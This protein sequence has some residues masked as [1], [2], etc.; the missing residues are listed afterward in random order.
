[1]TASV[2]T[3]FKMACRKEGSGSHVESVKGR[4]IYYI[5]RQ[6]NFLLCIRPHIHHNEATYI[7]SVC[8]V[9]YYKRYKGKAIPVKGRGG[10]WDRVTSWLPHFPDNRFTDGERQKM[11]TNPENCYLAPYI[12]ETHLNRQDR[13]GCVTVPDFCSGVIGL[14]LA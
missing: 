3:E 11:S 13:A 9:K 6:S 8:L 1:V 5:N 7:V 14:N 4:S 12:F 10:P 2:Y